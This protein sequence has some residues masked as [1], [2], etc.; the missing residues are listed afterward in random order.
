MWDAKKARK[1]EKITM[2]Q[3]DQ[4]VYIGLELAIAC[5]AVAGNILVCWAVCLNSNLQSITNFFVV[6]LAA[7][8]IAVGLLAIPLAIT[9][10]YYSFV[11][12]FKHFSLVSLKHSDGEIWVSI[13]L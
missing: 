9:V 11:V 6:S 13:C 10:G 3:N 2:L 8:D 1:R 5:L 7:A 4:L 12:S